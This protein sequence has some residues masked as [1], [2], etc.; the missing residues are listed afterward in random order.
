MVHRVSP[1]LVSV[2]GVRTPFLFAQ[3][4]IDMRLDG[5][6]NPKVLLTE[7]KAGIEM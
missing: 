7:S 4:S 3:Q 1:I 5:R 2:V 6:R